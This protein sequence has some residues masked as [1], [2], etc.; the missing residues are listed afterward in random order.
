MTETDK[1]AKELAIESVH[2]M[3][4]GTLEDFEAIIHPEATNR[5]GIA[6]PPACRERGP[7]AFH[8]TALW[9][10]SAYND[11]RFEI[12]DAV[13]EDDIVALYA[14]MSGTHSGTFVV[15]DA[16]GRPAQAFPATGK[17]FA[18]TQTHWF[19]MREEKVFEHWA[20]RDD[21]GQATQLGWVPPS[22]MYLVKS[23]LA[24]K[25]AQR[26]ARRGD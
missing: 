1:A 26:E 20:N 7:A 14:T 6:E 18:S 16:E 25:Q 17:R 12:H 8:A 19:R 9:L 11:L 4:S 13:I 10:R 21:I 23:Q 24:L 3:A 15:Y 5:E 22:P 2:L